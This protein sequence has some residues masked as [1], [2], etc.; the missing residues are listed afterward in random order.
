MKKIK[1][2]IGKRFNKLTVIEELP[3]SKNGRVFKCLCDCGKTTKVLINH[4][5]R[6]K[7]KSCGCIRKSLAIK[8]GMHESREYSTWENMVQRCT[9]PK[10]RK[11]HLYGGRGITICDRW[12]KS[13]IN[14]YED[15]GPRPDNTS[16][17]RLDND[18]GYYKENC[19]WS[20]PREQLVN[21]RYFHQHIKHDG[22]V[23]VL[24]DLIKE[25]NVDRETFKARVLRGL[26]FKQA[27]F[28]DVDIITLNVSNKHQTIYN[29]SQ[30]L[31]ETKFKE[32]DIIKL[33]DSD[34]ENPFH[35]YLI[36]YLVGFKKWP[37]K[38]Q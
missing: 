25:L 32:E 14:F 30:F 3:I 29:L 16:I 7:I 6:S 19:K 33:I 38:Y 15:M 24:E 9:N 5:L 11:Y 36:R 22:V 2:L 17:D 35:G 20:N 34:H 23:R 26:S 18:K 37:T 31:I 13:F 27:L 12:V 4:L 21:V 8:H 10:A 1:V 28:C